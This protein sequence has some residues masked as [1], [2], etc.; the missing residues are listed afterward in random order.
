MYTIRGRRACCSQSEEEENWGS[1]RITRFVSESFCTSTS[2]LLLTV[3]VL[4]SVFTPVMYVH[5]YNAMQLSRKWEDWIPLWLRVVSTNYTSKQRCTIT[6]VPSLI[7]DGWSYK[8]SYMCMYVY[9]RVALR[10]MD[11]RLGFNHGITLPWGKCFDQTPP[12]RLFAF[13]RL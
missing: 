10:L 12:F 8:C 4:T 5:V 3:F 13:S 7:I 9:Q 1:S 6:C 11:K 2:L